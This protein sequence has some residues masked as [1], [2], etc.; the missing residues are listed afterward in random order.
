M[1][2]VTG[3]PTV[4]AN[5][6]QDGSANVNDDSGFGGITY[7][8]RTDSMYVVNMFDNTIYRITGSSNATGTISPV[9]FQPDPTELGVVSGFQA[10]PFGLD[11]HPV[12][13]RLYYTVH[14]FTGG[15]SFV[16]R[17][18]ALDANGDFLPLTDQIELSEV[19]LLYT[20]PS[21]RDQRGSRMPSSA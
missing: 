19:C 3:A 18:V 1:D 11:I 4:W 17:S 20:S 5:L 14:D 10:V 12:D 6:P 2:A 8:S 9:S 7:D 16:V 15:G 13:G 21:P